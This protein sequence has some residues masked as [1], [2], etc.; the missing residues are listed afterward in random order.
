M[1]ALRK[2]NSSRELIVFIIIFMTPLRMASGFQVSPPPGAG[3]SS[4]SS[5]CEK[6]RQ[7]RTWAAEMEL[8]NRLAAI[9]RTLKTNQADCKATFRDVDSPACLRAYND[10]ITL[11]AASLL[12]NGFICAGI[13]SAAVI[14]PNVLAP[15]CAICITSS[16]GVLA[17]GILAAEITKASC[18][19][20]AQNSANQCV[21][22]SQNTADNDAITARAE[23]DFKIAQ[24]DSKFFDCKAGAASN[25]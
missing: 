25:K 18:L 2:S 14:P 19:S 16:Y 12:T 15:G 1:T 3:G 23:Y 4:P 7:D 20:K 24:S 9:D 17:G 5:N 13:C 21:K 11:L 10:N 22:R 6:E 8:C